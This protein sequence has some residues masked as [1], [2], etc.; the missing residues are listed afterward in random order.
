MSHQNVG[1]HRETL[2]PRDSQRLLHHPRHAADQDLHHAK[3]IQYRHQCREENYR[4]QNTK[5]KRFQ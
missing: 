4:R 2:R 5:R 1:S 3:V